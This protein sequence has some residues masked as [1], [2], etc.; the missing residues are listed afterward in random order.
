MIGAQILGLIVSLIILL[1]VSIMYRQRKFN[2]INS[3]LWIMISLAI[4]FFS[5]MPTASITL[6]DFITIIRID[7]LM[8]SG[9]LLLL[10]IVLRIHIRLEDTNR[11]LTLL[12]QHLALDQF[13]KNTKSQFSKSLTPETKPVDSKDT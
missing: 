3:F 12:V 13:Q 5:I 4:I 2:R 7:A 8:I 11:T 1:T 6:L 9:I 10:V